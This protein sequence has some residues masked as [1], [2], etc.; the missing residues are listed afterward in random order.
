M[1]SSIKQRGLRSFA[2]VLFLLMLLR[3]PAPAP[4]FADCTPSSGQTSCTTT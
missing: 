1:V 2:V 3:L 4:T